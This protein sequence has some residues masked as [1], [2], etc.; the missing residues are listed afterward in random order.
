MKIGIHVN[1]IPPP[2][3]IDRLIT[4]LS[5][6]EH[7]IWVFGTFVKKTQKT[8]SATYFG[9]SLF[10]FLNYSKVFHL[11]KYNFLLCFFRKKEKKSLD[12]LIRFSKKLKQDQ[13]AFYPILWKRPDVLHVQ[14]SASVEQFSWVQAFGIKL[15]V[16]FRGAHINYSPLADLKLADTYRQL[17]PKVEGFHGVSHAICKE[18]ARYGA[19]MDKCRVVYSGFDL[20]GFPKPTP[21]MTLSKATLKIVSVGRAHWKKGYHYALDAIK[22]LQERGITVTY[23]IVGVGLDEELTF[24]RADL[25]LLEAVVF[26]SKLPFQ[27]VLETVRQADVFLLPSVEEGIANVVIEAM[28]LGTPVITTNCGGM[29]ELVTDGKT[30]FVVPVRNPEAIADA[31]IRYQQLSL[32]KVN[33]MSAAAYDK[34]CAQHSESQ[35]VDGMLQLYTDV[36]KG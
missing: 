3:F 27:Q 25:G 29:E 19:S 20:T 4:G 22:I 24:Q 11:I 10:S 30:G 21:K 35:M 28:L 7:Q 17:F 14:W 12:K 18:A 16:S 26:G 33:H 8:N 1:A 34:A 6:T 9:Y 31:I 2:E 13:A 5:K 23:H 36:M 15:V 32:E